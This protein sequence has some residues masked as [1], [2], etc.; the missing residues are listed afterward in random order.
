MLELKEYVAIQ[1]FTLSLDNGK[2][3]TYVK[4]GE[5]IQFDGLNVVLRGE[6]GTARPLSKVIGEW[7]TPTGVKVKPAGKSLAVPSRNVSGGKILE[8]SDYPS[9]PAVGVKNQ[10]N[11]SVEALLKNYDKTPE[12]KIVNGKREVTSD[13]DDIKKEVTVI[14]DDASVVRKVSAVDEAATNKN[15][16]EIGK[17]TER[18]AVVLSQEGDVAKET[19]YSGKKASDE[20]AKKLTIDYEAS[21]VEVRKTSDT[22]PKTVK[23]SDKM[24]TYETDMEVGETSY[25]ATQTTDVGSSTQAQIEQR[26]DVKKTASKKK[27]VTKKKAAAKKKTAVKKKATSKKAAP[28]KPVVDET[29]DSVDDLIADVPEILNTNPTVARGL[30]VEAEGQEAVVISKVT[31]DNKSSVQVE[32]GITSRV[33]VGASEDMDIGEVEFSSNNDFEEPEA[34]FSAGEDTP[35]DASEADIIGLDGDEADIIEDSD[36][37]DLNDILS[38]V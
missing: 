9:D 20:K 27:A 3:P 32:D 5:K 12:T 4:T 37:I 16:V 29:E 19:N 36:D 34:V 25:P 24:E 18:K 28:I 26:K 6:Q 2:T 7:I 23:A 14:N 1:D 10:P 17:E 30:V 33:T 22:T 13:L 21:G 15:S 35:Y 38:E 11:D 8:H 31:R